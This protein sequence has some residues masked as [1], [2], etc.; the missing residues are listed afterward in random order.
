MNGFAKP[1]FLLAVSALAALAS[2][3]CSPGGAAPPLKGAAIGGPLAL[4]DEDGRPFGEAQLEGRYR[5]VYFG[6]THCPDVCPTDLVQIGQAMRRFEK[7]DPSRASRVQPLFVTV[8]PERDTPAVLKEFTA[9]FH[10]RLVGLT[11]TPEQIA[12]V[13]KSFG[14]YY[15]KEPAANGGYVMN[16]SRL[17]FLFGPEGEPIALLPQDEGADAIAAELDRWVR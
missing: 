3:A 4:T 11:G 5:I 16:H 6:F 7:Q 2:A 13:G 14:I 17:A 12:K 15:A 8:D 1:R 9:A 10:P